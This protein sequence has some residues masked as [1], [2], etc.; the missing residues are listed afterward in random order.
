MGLKIRRKQT[1]GKKILDEIRTLLMMTEESIPYRTQS[2]PLCEAPQTRD[3]R[4]S[5]PYR[6]QSLSASVGEAALRGTRP[7]MDQEKCAAKIRKALEAYDDYVR[8]RELCDKTKSRILLKDSR[9]RTEGDIKCMEECLFLAARQDAEEIFDALLS[10]T[11]SAAEIDS[12]WEQKYRNK[13]AEKFGPQGMSPRL[14]DADHVPGI[15]AA[16]L[17]GDEARM[18]AEFAFD[19]G[20]EVDHTEEFL[21]YGAMAGLAEYL[22]DGEKLEKI[23]GKTMFTAG[24]AEG[25]ILETVHCHD[26][27]TAA[28]LSEKQ[29]TIRYLTEILGEIPWSRGL[30]EGI[31]YASKELQDFMLREFPE[32]Q[33]YVS[34]SAIVRAR[35][36]RFLEILMDGQKNRTDHWTELA[37]WIHTGRGWLDDPCVELQNLREEK[38][39][40]DRLLHFV[41]ERKYIP[42][43]QT[44]LC[45][46]ALS[47]AGREERCR[48][49]FQVIF[50]AGDVSREDFSWFAVQCIHGNLKMLKVLRGV[51]N[52]TRIGIDPHTEELNPEGIFKGLLIAQGGLDRV[53]EVFV[54]LNTGPQLDGIVRTALAENKPGVIKKA[55]QCGYLTGE[56]ALNAYEKL[57]EQGN[58]KEELLAV[59]IALA[60]KEERKERY[61]REEN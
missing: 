49:L 33:N 25:N 24:F 45:R 35:N 14:W 48:M 43:I 44:M 61:E 59:L 7:G 53:M 50:E 46:D 19:T 42:G 6:M 27:F 1:P 2:V 31:L 54:P 22:E 20:F 11:I 17:T 38:Q 15:Y 29:E 12:R 26:L 37:D 16:V 4:K 9:Y 39:F 40:L 10:R 32:I 34:L 51:P 58:V 21:L 36:T 13:L 56:N 55:I 30:E 8:G 47:S 60:Q 5:V 52:F 57:L 3:V 28:V 41:P 23:T 18:E